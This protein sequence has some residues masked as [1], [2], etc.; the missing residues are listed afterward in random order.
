MTVS[1]LMDSPADTFSYS[2]IV[3]VTVASGFRMNVGIYELQQ[4]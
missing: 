2:P 3:P 4:P 1:P